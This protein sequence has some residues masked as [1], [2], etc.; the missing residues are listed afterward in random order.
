MEKKSE[1]GPIARS[2]G[3]HM[4]QCTQKK[5]LLQFYTMFPYNICISSL[6]HLKVSSPSQ[7]SPDRMVKSD[8]CIAA[9][10]TRTDK[11]SQRQRDDP[12]AV[13]Y[14]NVCVCGCVCWTAPCCDPYTI[15]SIVWPSE[16]TDGKPEPGFSKEILPRATTDGQ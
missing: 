14:L 16:Q 7:V 2:T 5:G 10:Q 15:G 9:V 6:A 13:M 11:T 8:G 12:I 4:C 1:G 3:K